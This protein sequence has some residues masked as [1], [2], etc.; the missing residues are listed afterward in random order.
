MGINAQT[1]AQLYHHSFLTH[2]RWRAATVA[3]V[4]QAGRGRWKVENAKN[5]VRQT[6]GYPIAQNLGHGKRDLAALLRNL[7]LLAFLFHPVLQGCDEKYALLR[8][9]FVRRQTFFDDMR[10]LTR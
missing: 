3:Q 5:H 1:G 2:H 8:Q 7:T 6:K 10:A 4:A 9:V